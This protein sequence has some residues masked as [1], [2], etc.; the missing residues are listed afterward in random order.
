LKFIT[1]EWVMIKGHY[2]KHYNGVICEITDFNKATDKYLVKTVK[3]QELMGATWLHR[4]FITHAPLSLN[5]DDREAL[6]AL[7][8]DLALATN[9]YKWCGELGGKLNEF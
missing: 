8:M 5:K 4:E 6:N 7:Y 2:N 9:D 1:G 3:G